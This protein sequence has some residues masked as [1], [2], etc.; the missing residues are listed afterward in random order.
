M[1]V[2]VVFTFAVVLI[3]LGIGMFFGTGATSP[4]A[5]IPAAFGGLLLLTGA[6]ARH[7]RLYWRATAG[8][9]AVAL[10]GLLST[11]VSLMT[12]SEVVGPTAVVAK[13]I[14]VVLFG[15]LLLLCLLSFWQKRQPPLSRA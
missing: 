12:Y 11:I 3:G 2:K 14:M 9:T 10:I 8:T 5:L 13:V 1:R 15:W 4:T 7:Q 6:L